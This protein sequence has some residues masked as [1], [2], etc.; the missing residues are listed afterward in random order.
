MRI[1][2]HEA[3]HDRLI[4]ALFSR[5]VPEM[6]GIVGD[7]IKWFLAACQDQA[8]A[9]RSVLLN[10]TNEHGVTIL[11][12]ASYAGNAGLLR[13]LQAAMHRSEQKEPVLP[14]PRMLRICRRHR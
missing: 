10:R 1:D 4:I 6:Q 12:A 14:A 2:D 3:L 13:V 9:F 5:E 8:N 7:A 11:H